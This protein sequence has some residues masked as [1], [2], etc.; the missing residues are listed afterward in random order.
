MPSLSSLTPATPA[1]QV[2]PSSTP[3]L[4]VN[5]ARRPD[6]HEADEVKLVI[7]QI[8]CH[9]IDQGYRPTVTFKSAAYHKPIKEVARQA[10]T[11]IGVNQIRRIMEPQKKKFH[12]WQEIVRLPGVGWDEGLKPWILELLL[13]GLHDPPNLVDPNLGIRLSCDFLDGLVWHIVWKITSFTSSVQWLHG[14][15]AGLTGRG[16]VLLGAAI[17]RSGCIAGTGFLACQ[18]HNFLACHALALTTTS[19]SFELS[20]AAQTAYSGVPAMALCGD[21]LLVALVGR[22]LEVV[23]V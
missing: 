16:G 9:Y 5:P 23:L 3:P 7:F 20:S 15:R 2:A 14:R 4:P 1:A 18:A 22:V 6:S 19:S 17:T 8:M 12:L 11:E 13:L 10:N 21:A